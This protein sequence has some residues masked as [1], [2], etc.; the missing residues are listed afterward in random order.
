MSES[1]GQ[2][3]PKARYF[4]DY[5]VG[6]VFEFGEYV[7]D[8]QELVEF[9]RAYDPQPFHTDAEAARKTHFGGLIASGWH[10]CS[11]LMRLMVDNYI[12]PAASLGSPGI[13]QIRW[14]QPVRPG[15][16]L[17]ARATVVETR[18]SR[19]KP[20]RG[21]VRTDYEVYNQQRELVMTMSSMGLFKCRGG[22]NHPAISESA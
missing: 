11:M 2:V 13:D 14:T 15:D 17:N 3:P 20:D 9:G 1:G 19:S 6:E 18:R 10:T 8:E 16:R 7:V 12:S 4:E 21:L 22:E 5:A